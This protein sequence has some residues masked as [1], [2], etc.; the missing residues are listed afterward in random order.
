M[1]VSIPFAEPVP[2][3]PPPVQAVD[4]GPQQ[5]WCEPIEP[6]LCEVDAHCSPAMDGTDRV[7]R[8]PWFADVKMCLA[9]FP[10]RDVQRWRKARMRVLVDE[11]C[12]PRDGCKPEQLA[13]YLETL[14]GRE[15]SWRPYKLVR[16]GED[17]E[18]SAKAWAG[19][20]SLVY[21]GN[22]TVDEPWRWTEARG[23]F[24][25]NTT[26]WLWRWDP[27]APPEA[28]CGE[29]EATIAHLRG[30][31]GRLRQLES[32]VT[33][34]GEL[35]SGTAE[36][37]SSPSWYSV[38]LVNSGNETCPAKSGKRLRVREHFERS[39]RSRGLDPH[40]AVTRA[41]LGETVAVEEQAAFAARVRRKMD[42]EAGAQPPKQ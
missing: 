32:G 7:C 2:P 15:S 35:H 19:K 36:G 26:Y 1:R 3:E 33:C 38:S 13:D 37:N 5:S 22:P 10:S 25:Q 20:A 12:K 42:E 9:K 8:T 17:V 30:A 31:R 11:I 4:D 24:S 29:V 14:I 40:G 23:Y 39:A 27:M 18:A 16:L 28:L 6:S 41:M 21:A 34:G